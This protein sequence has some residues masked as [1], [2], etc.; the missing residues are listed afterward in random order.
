MKQATVLAVSV[1]LGAS[2]GASAFAQEP[3]TAELDATGA[4][5]NPDWAA[6]GSV[7]RVYP[8]RAVR[9]RVSGEA[10]LRCRVETGGR[11]SQCKVVSESPQG[12]GFGQ[13]ALRLAQAHLIRPMVIDDRVAI[14]VGRDVE[15]K[16]GFRIE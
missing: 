2:V 15:F 14:P 9:A 5:T 4:I 8:E 11:L 13:A 16:L 3:V 10:R 12:F 6:R 1:V 7:G